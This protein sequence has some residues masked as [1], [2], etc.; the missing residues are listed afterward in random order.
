MVTKE[1]LFARTTVAPKIAQPLTSQKDIQR[2]Q[3]IRQQ[4][5]KQEQV[6]KLQREAEPIKR[7]NVDKINNK[8]QTFKQRIQGFQ[9]RIEQARQRIE[10]ARDNETRRELQD[11]IEKYEASIKAYEKGVSE[12]EK[13]KTEYQDFKY[14]LV[15]ANKDYADKVGRYAEDVKDSIEDEY[16][17]KVE[18]SERRRELKKLGYDKDPSKWSG[19]F[20]EAKSKLEGLNP[21]EYAREYAKL[22]DTVKQAFLS[23]NQYEQKYKEAQ[24]SQKVLEPEIAKQEKSIA[25]KNIFTGELTSV[26]PEIGRKDPLL[27]PVYVDSKGREIE[28]NPLIIQLENPNLFPEAVKGKPVKT[29]VKSVSTL[30]KRGAEEISEFTDPIYQSFITSASKAEKSRIKESIKKDESTL[31]SG[32]VVVAGFGAYKL[33]ESDRQKIEERLEKNKER[34]NLIETLPEGGVTGKAQIAGAVGEFTAPIV[35]GGVLAPGTGGLSLGVGIAY[36]I[37]M[38]TPP[39]LNLASK[40]IEKIEN[41]V[42]DTTRKATNI[43]WDGK[44][45]KREF[46]EIKDSFKNSKI[47]RLS[48]YII[49]NRIKDFVEDT[50]D[51]KK[52]TTSKNLDDLVENS[53]RAIFSKSDIS[54]KGKV[55]SDT[56]KDV[57]NF[58]STKIWQTQAY[59]DIAKQIE[60]AKKERNEIIKREDILNKEEVVQSYDEYINSLNQQKEDII[61]KIGIIVFSLGALLLGGGKAIFSK[62]RN[63]KNIKLQASIYDDA[64]ERVRELNKV[65]SN[66]TKIRNSG[67][68]SISD[69]LV[70]IINVK[71]YA[72]DLLDLKVIKKVDDVKSLQVVQ[73]WEAYK[74]PVWKVDKFK[75][76]NSD[77]TTYYPRLKD[78]I[79]FKNYVVYNIVD[80]SG[81]ARSFAVVTRA[82]KPINRFRNVKNAIKYGVGKKVVLSSTIKDSD[83]INSAVFNLRAGQLTPSERLISIG[84]DISETRKG[85]VTKKRTSLADSTKLTPEEYWGLS[86]TKA[87]TVVES[88]KQKPKPTVISAEDYWFQGTSQIERGTTRTISTGLTVDTGTLKYVVDQQIELLKRIKSPKTK[89]IIKVISDKVDNAIKSGKSS[90]TI[91]NK[92]ITELP[93]EQ[94]N[95]LQSATIGA[96]TSLTVPKLTPKIKKFDIKVKSD[97]VNKLSR[98]SVKVGA[99]IDRIQNNFESKR[100]V[101]NIT[102][103]DVKQT[104]RELNKEKVEV[105]Q[106]IK[107][108]EK[109]IRLTKNTLEEVTR[110]LQ[111]NPFAQ[112]SEVATRERTKLDVLQRNIQRLKLR[113]RQIT[114]FQQIVQSVDFRQRDISRPMPTDTN[115]IRIPSWGFP[116]D[117][118]KKKKVKESDDFWGYIPE[119]RV[120]GKWKP[121]SQPVSKPKAQ[122]K[123]IE[124]TSKELSQSF[125]LRKTDIRIPKSESKEYSSLANYYK[126]KEKGF[127]VWIE[128]PKAKLDS[129]S[130]KKKLKKARKEKKKEKEWR[131]KVNKYWGFK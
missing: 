82:N 126:K 21:S 12:L 75:F 44:I 76:P 106:Q 17:R 9:Q 69:T 105:T 98:N 117:S 99:R 27:R 114:Q 94:R 42:E 32:K 110:E 60:D 128:K 29:E 59:K 66:P 38:A 53:V 52:I 46:S 90:V 43:L 23:S 104:N 51:I 107:Q 16:E 30:L 24:Q 61:A 80:K 81:Q 86:P 36:D 74:Q 67:G 131:K 25:Y 88:V 31:K 89:R 50:N 73:G 124:I 77:I 70:G 10:K 108:N 83:I 123:A 111:K 2:I 122:K 57:K 130:E 109:A 119:V 100:F 48:S 64:V 65:T 20:A 129:P 125:R 62:Y 120:K 13:G 71:K 14:D 33:S 127:D 118:K 97:T 56:T 102:K 28:T 93:L 63:A 78:E 54:N 116:S 19:E 34:L 1:Q 3:E 121:I 8:I 113:Q 26:A 95:A 7:Q 39:I 87:K 41:F 79:F 11:D 15:L 68:Q 37:L 103:S 22:S 4:R 112:I 40:G 101:G 5:F 18:R 47:G 6:R 35:A 49:T 85:I 92:L 96:S 72:N 55:V 91:P 115:R 84:F 45:D 58:I